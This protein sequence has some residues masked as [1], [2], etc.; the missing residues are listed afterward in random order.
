M[1]PR[2]IF[3]ILILT[4]VQAGRKSAQNSHAIHRFI[5]TRTRTT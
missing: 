5:T 4:P 1:Y 3:G 2:A